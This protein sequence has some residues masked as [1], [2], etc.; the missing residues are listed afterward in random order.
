MKLL[1]MGEGP[2]EKKI[3]DLLLQNRI[4]RKAHEKGEYCLADLLDGND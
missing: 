3:L 2:N 1:V 4:R